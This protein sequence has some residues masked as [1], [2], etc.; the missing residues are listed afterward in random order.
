MAI[1]RILPKFLSGADKLLD[2]VENQE[3]RRNVERRRA[4]LRYDL[5]RRA[6]LKQRDARVL[7]HILEQ[8]EKNNAY[9]RQ[10]TVPVRFKLARHEEDDTMIIL[11][12]IMLNAEMLSE[13]AE[14]LQNIMD[15]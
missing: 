11:E 3:Q 7:K 6:D 4:D 1:N 15:Y 2:L 9:L 13:E 5:R 8:L 10:L 14:H 12:K